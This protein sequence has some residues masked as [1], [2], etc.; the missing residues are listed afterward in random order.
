VHRPDDHVHAVHGVK[1]STLGRSGAGG[2]LLARLGHVRRPP[3]HGDVAR[4][5]LAHNHTLHL[6]VVVD[7]TPVEVDG[8]ARLGVRVVVGIEALKKKS[9][10][11]DSNE[12]EADLASG[13]WRVIGLKVGVQRMGAAFFSENVLGNSA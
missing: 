13:K 6:L 11:K 1:V 4:G 8:T 9:G 7:Q 5:V 3:S 2:E 10:A 12:K